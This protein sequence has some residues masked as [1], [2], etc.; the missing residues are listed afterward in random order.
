M[1]S[2]PLQIFGWFMGLRQENSV[3]VS[4]FPGYWQQC[5]FGRYRRYGFRRT[6]AK[7]CAAFLAA[8]WKCNPATIISKSRPVVNIS[9]PATGSFCELKKVRSADAFTNDCLSCGESRRNVCWGSWKKHRLPSSSE[10]V[11]D[12]DSRLRTIVLSLQLWLYASSIRMQDLRMFIAI[13][14]PEVLQ[15]QKLWSLMPGCFCRDENSNCSIIIF[16]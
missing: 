9:H 7:F 12:V 3:V 16:P 2:I 11:R 14:S 6:G 10:T 5:C 1:P 4:N 15:Q 8:R 13:A